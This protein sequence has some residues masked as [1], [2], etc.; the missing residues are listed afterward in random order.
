MGGDAADADVFPSL[1]GFSGFVEP[2]P[3][4]QAFATYLIGSGRHIAFVQKQTY[5]RY[6]RPGGVPVDAFNP[7]FGTST[8]YRYALDLT[9]SRI[10]RQCSNGG[11]TWTPNT[12]VW[13][14]CTSTEVVNLDR[15]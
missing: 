14:S 13:R 12:A 7:E 4:Q 8:M 9:S 6:G 2:A 5:D 1:L 11:A 15:K 3:P 10:Y